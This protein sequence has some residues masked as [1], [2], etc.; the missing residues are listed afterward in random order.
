MILSLILTIVN[1]FTAFNMVTYSPS[2]LEKKALAELVSVL[3]NSQKFV[4]VHAAEYLIWT[5]HSEIALKEFLKEERLYSEEPK[6]RVVIWRVLAQAE[7]DPAR[8]QLWID[9]IYNAYKD[10]NGPDRTHATE[11]LAKLKQPVSRL[12]PKETEETLVSQD[13]NLQT[14]ALWASSFG[15]ESLFDKNRAKF[16]DMAL[17]DSDIIIRKI[18]AFVLRQ[19]KG[20]SLEQWERLAASALASDPAAETYVTFLVTALVTAPAGSD[21][22]TLEK[23]DEMLLDHVKYYSVGQRNELALALAEKGQEHHLKVLKGFMKNKNSA[24]IYD[25]SSEEAADLRAAAA[26]AILKINSR[27]N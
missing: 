18:S 1:L 13:R 8:K 24:G 19:S 4:K 9:K 7:Q 10:M 17:T 11:T 23:I 3:H 22:R 14:Y 27:E 26:Y 25:E 20:L 21:T 16:L 15:S 12:F 2:S 5:G 6:Y